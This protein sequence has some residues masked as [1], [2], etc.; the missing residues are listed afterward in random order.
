[1]PAIFFDFFVKIRRKTYGPPANIFPAHISTFMS[2]G[3]K[4]FKRVIV[5][6]GN[7]NL[8]TFGKTFKQA[9]QSLRR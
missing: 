6:S 2:L 3:R 5:V 9:R 7:G 1:M 4:T 8:R